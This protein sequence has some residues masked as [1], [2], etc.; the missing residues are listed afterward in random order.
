MKIVLLSYNNLRKIEI[1]KRPSKICKTPYVADAILL[2]DSKKEESEKIE[3]LLHTPSLGCCGLCEKESIIYGIPLNNENIKCSYRTIVS[4]DSKNRN[5]K[6]GVDP[7][8]GEKIVELVFQ[9]NL[10]SNLINIKNYK[11]QVTF[12]NSR[13]DF[14]GELYDDKQFIL[15]VKSVP[16]Q[17]NNIAYFPDG[18]RKKK[19]DLVSPRAFKHIEELS[20]ICQNNS[21]IYNC[22]MCYVIQRND[23][24]KFMISANDK[25]YKHAVEKSMKNNVKIL[26]IVCE[27]DDDGKLYL[28]YNKCKLFHDFEDI[29]TLKDN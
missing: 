24:N 27:W 3:F 26:I 2:E 5:Y 12:N 15:E 7:S 4:F 14:A 23:I 6:V 10:L 22:Y 21:D 25:I 11:K 29:F 17:E 8:H 9:N 18:Y 28:I 16:L 1:I 20:Q 13:F 19:T